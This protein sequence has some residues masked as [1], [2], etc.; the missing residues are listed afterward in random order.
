MDNIVVV[1]AFVA[2]VVLMV[3]TGLKF[4]K[5]RVAADNSNPL[6]LRPLFGTGKTESR[7]DFSCERPQERIVDGLK[8]GLRVKFLEPKIGRINGLILRIKGFK[9]AFVACDDG[10]IRRV[11][12]HRLTALES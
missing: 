2:I 12:L 9:R 10:Q 8:R 4:G 5:R 3:S 7:R 6:S 1:I 11:R